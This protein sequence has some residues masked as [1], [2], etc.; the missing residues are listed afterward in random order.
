[1]NKAWLCIIEARFYCKLDASDIF[2]ATVKPILS[3]GFIRIFS[4]MF[5]ESKE[6]EN[7]GNTFLLMF[8]RWKINYVKASCKYL[9]FSVKKK[10]SLTII[11][12]DLHSLIVCAKVFYFPPV[13]SPFLS[14]EYWLVNN[15][16]ILLSSL[17]ETS[18]VMYL[19]RLFSLFS[20]N[21]VGRLC[22]WSISGELQQYSMSRSVRLYMLLFLV[23]SPYVFYC[24]FIYLGLGLIELVGSSMSLCI[25]LISFQVC[26][27]KRQF[28]L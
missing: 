28:C 20:L 21:C 14:V 13:Y 17:E 4:W 10:K 2:A 25:V 8:V 5:K 15:G 6:K 3:F 12:E 11:Y 23:S 27:W 18:P 1:M 16:Y 24:L 22:W 26:F 19:P 7:N 9:M